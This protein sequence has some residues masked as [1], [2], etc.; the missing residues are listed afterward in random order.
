MK[1]VKG[2][3]LNGLHFDSR[4]SKLDVTKSNFKYESEKENSVKLW[5]RSQCISALIDCLSE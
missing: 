3:T 2:V 1:S 4:V 5:A